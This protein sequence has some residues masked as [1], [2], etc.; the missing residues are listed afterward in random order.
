M[1][2]NLRHQ[3]SLDVGLKKFAFI[4]KLVV[5]R[6][7]KNFLVLQCLPSNGLVRIFSAKFFL[8]HQIDYFGLKGK[9]R[10]SVA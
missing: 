6:F 4:Q 8:L 7:V 1:D 2:L 10:I 5:L 9:Q 3:L